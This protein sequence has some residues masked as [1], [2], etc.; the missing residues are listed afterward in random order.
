MSI[1]KKLSLCAVLLA[2]IGAVAAYAADGKTV[3]TV[4]KLRGETWFVRMAEGVKAFGDKNP[5]F[6]TNEIGPGKADAAQQKTMIEDL[7]AKKVDAIAVVPFDPPMLEGTLKRAME[8]GI[9]VVTHE[10]D[11]LKNTPVDLEAFDNAAFGAHFN[12]QLAKCMG[13]EGKWTSFVGS[14]G[15]L[16]HVQWADG[17]AENA[18]KKYPKMELVSPKNESFNDAN[19]A[20]E[21]AKEIL[22]KYPDIKGIE[23][24]SAVDPIGIGRAIEEA[25]LIGKVCVIGIG[26]PKD[27]SRYLESGAVKSISFWD[28]KDAGYAMNVLAKMLIEGKPFTE[29]MDLGVP[30][31]NKMHL[32]KGPGKGVILTGQAWV[33]V[34]KSNYKD[35]PF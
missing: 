17:S 9:K 28:P 6:T 15:S 7:I 22:R 30:G 18:K 1:V 33:D 20:Y 8:K 5:G 23:G 19:T 29:G 31:Y 16:T 32:K 35:Y 10:A 24:G 13:E 3:V 27:T 34:D 2:G 26:L 12:D 14:L 11:N 25:G 4:V 21:K